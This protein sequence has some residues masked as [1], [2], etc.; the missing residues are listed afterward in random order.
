[1][2]IILWKFWSHVD[3]R[4]QKIIYKNVKTCDMIAERMFP[5]WQLKQLKSDTKPNRL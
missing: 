1:M 5:S 3:F 4:P 2:N